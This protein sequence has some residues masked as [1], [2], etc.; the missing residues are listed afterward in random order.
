MNVFVFVADSFRYDYL[1]C[2]GNPWIKTPN[3]DAFAKRAVKFNRAYTEGMPTLQ[4]RTA[5]LTGRYTFP[6]INWHKLGTEHPSIAEVLWEKGMNSALVT[7]VHHLHKPTMGYERGFDFVRF[8]RGQEGD[9][10]ILDG[11]L[12]EPWEKF[13]KDP[14]ISEEEKML[15][16]GATPL[17]A[18]RF[19]E[20]LEQ[21]L[22]NTYGWKTEEDYFCAQVVRGAIEWV[23]AQ[24]R[25]DN[26][27]LWIDC[28]DPHEP[29]DPPANYAHLYDAR[30]PGYA[31]QHII[32]PVPL[33]VEG[34]L[35]D[36]EQA[37]IRNLYASEVTY[38][39][40]WFGVF[41]KKLESLGLME[42]SMIVFTSDHGEPLGK[43]E[44]GHG[45]MRKCR[46]WP[47]EEMARVPLLVYL[48]KGQAISET[49]ALAQD[50]DLFPSIMDFLGLPCPPSVQGKSLL[51][52]IQKK[53][54]RLRDE[55][56]AACHRG[57]WKV[58]DERHS[59]IIWQPNML[60]YIAPPE[61]YDLQADPYELNNIIRDRPEPALD[62]SYRMHKFLN[63]LKRG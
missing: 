11:P 27:F 49:S 5:M 25:R 33:P 6:T 32:H 29:W 26:L 45:L 24:K 58:L 2:Y 22:R 20:Q 41:L 43:G 19:R 7:D 38:V 44:H 21:Y 62:L 40:T 23:E 50:C 31:G 13:F 54:E 3:L 16:P 60:G 34:Y 4:A 28:F 56:Y 1:G 36:A 37:D 15:Y 12:R 59:Y 14:V 55:A 35:S 48:P 51:P 47:Y 63:G 52:L 61:L 8:I 46:P 17:A 10:Y 9:P 18:E 42:N 57:G 30:N 53:E 39:D